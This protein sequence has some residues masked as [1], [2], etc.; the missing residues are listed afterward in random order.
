MPRETPDAIPEDG[1]V[2]VD[3]IL[4]EAIARSEDGAKLLLD[5]RSIVT[6]RQVA[7]IA[8]AAAT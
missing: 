5:M 8:V 2:R 7:T 3:P 4:L 6:M 1:S